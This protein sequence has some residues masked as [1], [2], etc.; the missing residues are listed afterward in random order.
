MQGGW[1]DSV[2][3]GEMIGFDIEAACVPARFFL[4]LF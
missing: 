4:C 2:P 3:V 1:W